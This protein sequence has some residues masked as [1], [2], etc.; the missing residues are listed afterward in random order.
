MV[1]IGIR[2][3]CNVVFTDA[4][5]KDEKSSTE[6]LSETL[7]SSFAIRLPDYAPIYA[8]EFVAIRLALYEIPNNVS[9]I[10]LRANCLSILTSL[11]STNNSL[12]LWSLHFF[13]FHVM[14]KK[15]GICG[16][17]HIVD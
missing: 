9:R 15:F 14:L 7:L 6:I 5:Q 2:G 8:A 10:I 1:E 16:Y 11:E 12:L 13:S 4:A 17:M 3:H